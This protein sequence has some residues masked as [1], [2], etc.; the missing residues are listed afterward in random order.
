MGAFGLV[1]NLL[2]WT[3]SDYANSGAENDGKYTL[4]GE[5]QSSIFISL[6]FYCQA[7]VV[8]LYTAEPFQKR[9]YRHK[10]LLVLLFM[11]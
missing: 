6:L 11:T 9:I 10:L 5:L 3:N 7:V 2:V 4:S 8:S 1:L